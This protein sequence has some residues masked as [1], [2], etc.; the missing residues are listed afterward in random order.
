MASNISIGASGLDFTQNCS[1]TVIA[2][3]TFLPNVDVLNHSNHALMTDWLAFWRYALPLNYQNVTDDQISLYANNSTLVNQVFNVSRADTVFVTNLAGSPSE[4]AENSDVPIEQAFAVCLGRHCQSL[5]Y[6]LD[7]A[8]QENIYGKAK[9]VC[10]I[11]RCGYA[12][13]GNTELAGIGV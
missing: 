2:Y 11:D 10:T 7:P 5:N 3:H 4:I 12:N 6:T 8:F 1:S 13:P 9:D